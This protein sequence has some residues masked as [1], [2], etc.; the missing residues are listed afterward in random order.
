MIVCRGI[1]TFTRVLR[2]VCVYVIGKDDISESAS[3]SAGMSACVHIQHL[4]NAKQ[5]RLNMVTCIEA[6]VHEWKWK[7]TCMRTHVFVTMC[8]NAYEP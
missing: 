3:T 6:Q 7:S 5:D 1:H 2:S 4:N 8:I